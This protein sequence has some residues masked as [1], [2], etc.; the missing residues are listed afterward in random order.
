[1]DAPIQSPGSFPFAVIAKWIFI[2]SII[3]GPI[4]LSVAFLDVTSSSR[5]KQTKATAH[6]RQIHL[7]LQE[8]A[9]D[10]DGKFPA[11]DRSSNGAYR[12]LFNRKFQDERIFYVSGCAWHQSLPEGITKPDN[13]VGQPPGYTL[14]LERG[15]NHWA[16]TTD[17]GVDSMGYLP[18]I[19]DGFSET[20]GIYAPDA[21]AKGGIWEGKAI[22]VRVDGSAKME[23]LAPD[24]RVYGKNANGTKVDIFSR[25]YGTNPAK[26]LNPW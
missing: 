19:M 7:A 21:A 4:L 20:V 23:K 18:L 3:V 11:A 17:L 24:L 13:E 22:V 6:A 5:D 12:Q 1:M 16:Y 14:G 9:L 10:H 8:F 25:D 2:F 26:L 15:E